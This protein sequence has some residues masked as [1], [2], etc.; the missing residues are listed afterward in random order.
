MEVLLTIG[1]PGR[2]RDVSFAG[3][4][5]NSQGLQDCVASL[6]DSGAGWAQAFVPSRRPGKGRAALDLDVISRDL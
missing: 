6:L 3:G 1:D 4:P 2:R 5:S